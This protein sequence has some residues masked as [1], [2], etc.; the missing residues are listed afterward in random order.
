MVGF[1]IPGNLPEE[2]DGL[3]RDCGMSSGKHLGK[4]G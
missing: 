1:D 2:M 3:L 4:A